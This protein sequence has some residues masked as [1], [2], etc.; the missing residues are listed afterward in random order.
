MGDFMDRFVKLTKE[1]GGQIMNRGMKMV[2]KIRPGLSI[3]HEIGSDVGFR[4]NI[5]E[6]SQYI[7]F[8]ESP[9]YIFL[10][11]RIKPHF[12]LFLNDILSLALKHIR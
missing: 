12:F 1:L 2:V 7:R 10:I 8:N 5:D 4:L 11:T 6:A 3:N 9:T